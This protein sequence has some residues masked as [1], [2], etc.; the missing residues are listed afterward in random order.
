[1]ISK[2]K[3]VRFINKYYLNGTVGST[4]FN[5]K[6]D[7]QRLSTRF[8]SGDKSLLGEV[9]M[10][11]WGYEDADVGVYDTEQLLKLISVLDDTI[12]LSINKTGDTAFSITLSDAYSAINYMLSDTSIINEPPQMKTIPEFELSIDVTPHFITKFIS[13]KSAL[14]EADTF[15]VITDETTSKTKLVIGYSAVNTHRVTIP[16]TSSTFEN[17]ENISFNANLF[18]EVLIANK[19]CESATLEISSQGLAKINFKIDDFDSTYWLV[20]ASEVD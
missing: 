5:S 7:N 17:I 10:S 8:I 15:T 19:D 4:V 2:Q 14:S 1:M 20:A 13:G 6:T 12:E 16:V 3:L 18:K 9:H 11:K